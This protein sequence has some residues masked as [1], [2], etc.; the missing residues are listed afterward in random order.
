MELATN[1]RVEGMQR[2]HW[3]FSGLF[4]VLVTFIVPLSPAFFPNMKGGS[5]LPIPLGE[6]GIF[7]GF[8]AV[9][10]LH[11]FLFC[12]YRAVRGSIPFALTF[13]GGIAWLGV[14]WIL[15]RELSDT[16]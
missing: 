15:T 11:F 6:V 12:G 10:A 3:F 13:A 2:L 14:C 16:L 1:E 5:M 9:F 4:G 7:H 8:F